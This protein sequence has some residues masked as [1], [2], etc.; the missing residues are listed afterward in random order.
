MLESLDYCRGLPV[1][2]GRKFI[3]FGRLK[4]PPPLVFQPAVSRW[5]QT[6]RLVSSPGLVDW[7]FIYSR[8]SHERLVRDGQ[9][10]VFNPPAPSS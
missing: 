8:D 6:D 7:A 10:A 3:H 5:F 4:F 2:A 1:K 9:S